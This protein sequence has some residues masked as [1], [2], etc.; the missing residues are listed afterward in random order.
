MTHVS[1]ADLI[2]NAT[3]VVCLAGLAFVPIVNVVVGA[4]VGASFA[5]T[6]GVF[7]GAVFAVLITAAQIGMMRMKERRAAQPEDFEQDVRLSSGAYRTIVNLADWRRSAHRP[8]R[9]ADV[10]AGRRVAA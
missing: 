2:V 3:A 4:F 9:D 5:G 7:V 1:S 8:I 6:I 10:A